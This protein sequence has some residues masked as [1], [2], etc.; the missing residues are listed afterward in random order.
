VVVRADGDAAGQEHDVG[1]VERARDRRARGLGVV[2]DLGR[3]RDL[4]PRAAG[5]RGQG[6]GV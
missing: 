1:A 3:A 2:A 6:H 4:R 5:E